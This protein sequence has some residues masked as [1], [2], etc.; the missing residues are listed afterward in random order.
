MTNAERFA[1]MI[2]FT[3][4]DEELRSAG[5]ES[6]AD[7]ITENFRKDDTLVIAFEDNSV[8]I[9]EKQTDE[10]HHFTIVEDTRSIAIVL[11][12]I[13]CATEKSY[14]LFKLALKENK[15]A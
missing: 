7:S 10:S 9:D 5:C 2:M 6:F 4:N 8:L 1:N 3:S 15:N 14:A 11:L 12:K 13:A